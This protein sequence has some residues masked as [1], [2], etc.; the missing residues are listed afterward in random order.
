[1]NRRIK[2]L[3]VL[4]AVI[5]MLTG[6]QDMKAIDHITFPVVLGI[7]WDETS[8]NIKIF[9]QVSTISTQIGGQNQSGTVYNVLESDGKTLKEA[10]DNIADHTQQYLSWKQLIAVVFTDKMAKRGIGTELDILSRN[11][12]IHLNS[13]LMITKENLRD[14]LG[15]APVVETGLPTTIVGVGPIGQQSTHTKAIT[16]KDFIVTS[17]NSQMEPVLPI[18]RIHRKTESQNEER[19]ELDYKGLGVFKDDRLIG[20]LDEDETEALLFILNTQNQGTFDLYEPQSA[21]DEKI[22]IS[23]LTTKTKFIPSIKNNEPSMTVKTKVEYDIYTYVVN[24]EINLDEIQKIDNLV[25]A[26]IESEIENV[27]RK[28]QYELKADVFGFGGKIYRKYPKYW[29]ENK[30]NWSEIFD[31][32][33]VFVEI[34]AQLRDTGQLSGSF[35][36]QKWKE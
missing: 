4:N 23:Q 15:M 2:A 32:M 1:M 3:L 5:L 9:A 30:Y 25:E 29:M 17:I 14:L 24:K 21:K 35:E 36:H 19:I 18:I 7:D 27:I 16:M 20:W 11:E 26:Y 8:N 12:Q 28:A 10:M 6:C 34:E 31:S 13:Y 33:E 22:S